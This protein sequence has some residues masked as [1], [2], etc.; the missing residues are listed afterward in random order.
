MQ[1]NTSNIFPSFKP[2][3]LRKKLSRPKRR[4]RHGVRS[5]WSSKIWS[6]LKGCG[7]CSII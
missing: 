7:E 1:M 3:K 5:R 6:H 2:R 4:K